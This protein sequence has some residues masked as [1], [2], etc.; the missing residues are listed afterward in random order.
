MSSPPI[1]PHTISHAVH[2]WRTL[3]VLLE[4]F[5]TL[6]SNAARELWLHRLHSVR[7]ALFDS[8]LQLLRLQKR[9]NACGFMRIPLI[10]SG[11]LQ[12]LPRHVDDLTI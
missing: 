2:E 1:P 10:V 7:P 5:E 12:R 6:P 9:A 11:R 4:Y 8:L 3:F